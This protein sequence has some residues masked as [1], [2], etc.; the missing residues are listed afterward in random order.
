VIF[1]NQFSFGRTMLLTGF[2]NLNPARSAIKAQFWNHGI[3]GAIPQYIALF[4]RF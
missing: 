4:V 1:Q 2:Q 3:Q